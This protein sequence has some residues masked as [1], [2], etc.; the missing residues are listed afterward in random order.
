MAAPAAQAYTFGTPAVGAIGPETTAF[1]WSADKCNDNDIPDQPSRAYRDASGKVVLINSHFTVRR[2]VGNTLAT[3]TQVCSPI[4]MSSGNNADPSRYDDKEWL[5]SPYTTDGGTTVYALI[6]AEFQ[7]Y[8]HSPGYCIRSGESF[9]DKQ[10][11]WYNALTLAKS[12]NG[13]ATFSHAAPPD[14]YVGGPPY[15]YSAG[16]GPDRLLPAEQHRARQGRPLL[17]A[18]ARGGL[19][20]AAL[21]K[22]ACGG[23]A[24]LGD[25]QS[26]RAWDG[27]AS[28]S[29]SATP[30][31]TRYDPAEG[32]V[33]AGVA[34]TGSAPSRRASRGAPT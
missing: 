21:R 10:K 28:T 29:G 31:G 17:R 6:H 34:G 26:W 4:A 9:A 13:G 33:R 11:C 3:V 27:T 2:K 7:G 16:I 24:D 12:T 22:P 32:V 5:A 1:D 18:R 8:N 30:T 23:P 25:P 19:R 20:R 14:H 15:R